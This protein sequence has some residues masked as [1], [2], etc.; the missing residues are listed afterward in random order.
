MKTYNSVDAMVKDLGSE[1]FYH[2]WKKLSWHKFKGWCGMWYIIINY[3]IS[4]LFYEDIP[5][6][7]DSEMTD[8]LQSITDKIKEKV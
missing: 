8:T 4:C 2:N 3:R 5:I 6:V 7:L 1:G